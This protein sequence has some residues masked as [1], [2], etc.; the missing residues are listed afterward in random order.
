MAFSD[1]KTDFWQECV[2]D[3]GLNG[4]TQLLRV[5]YRNQ[6]RV[7]AS[8]EMHRLTQQVVM[9]LNGDIIQIVAIGQPDVTS[10][11]AFRIRAGE[12]LCMRAACWHATRV[13]VSEINCLMLTRK[14]TTADLIAHLTRGTPLLESAIATFDEATIA[15]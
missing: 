13:E 8:L 4:E 15:F 11:T 9:P 5:N 14:S 3:P 7:V 1:S 12:G 6:D 10:L 2:F